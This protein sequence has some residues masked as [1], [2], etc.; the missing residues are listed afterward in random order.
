MRGEQVKNDR[1]T[2]PKLTADKAIAL[3]AESRSVYWH[4][5]NGGK[6]PEGP[7]ATFELNGTHYFYLGKDIGTPE[8]YVAYLSKAFTKETAQAFLTKRLDSKYL[9]KRNGRLAKVDADKGSLAEWKMAKAWLVKETSTEKQFKFYVPIGENYDCETY[10]LT[11]RYIKGAG[12]RI[13]DDPETEPVGRCPVPGAKTIDAASIRTQAKLGMKYDEVNALFGAPHDN[14]TSAKDDRDVWRY[15]I[16]QRDDYRFRAESDDV[17]LEG[18]KKGKI[19]IQLFITWSE[20]GAIA[21]CTFYYKD[22]NGKV[23]EERLQAGGNW[24]Q[25]V[26]Q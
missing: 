22:K 8:K 5:E 16:T 9:V 11:F 12:W 26:I 1:S 19:D 2:A 13:A 20:E 3:A 23:C 4:A 24:Q 6:L 7:L 17:D 10:K 18:I 15:D 14:L 21:G 25:T